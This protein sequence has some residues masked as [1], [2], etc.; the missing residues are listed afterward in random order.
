MLEAGFDMNV[1]DKSGET[2]LHS[3]ASTITHSL[4]PIYT[5]TPQAHTRTPGNNPECVKLLIENGS[6]VQWS[7][8]EG[9]G[10]GEVRSSFQ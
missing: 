3:A 10:D 8:A 2:P 6:D 5:I 9:I 4:T 1:Q 7:V